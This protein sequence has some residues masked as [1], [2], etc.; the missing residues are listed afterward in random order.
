M[1]ILS[2]NSPFF[3]FRNYA[4]GLKY[5]E[6]TRINYDIDHIEKS[7]EDEALRLESKANA[8][9]I[10]EAWK[11][12]TGLKKPKLV[13]LNVSGGGSRSALWV[14]N[15]L[16]NL[17]KRTDFAVSK[18]LQMITGASGGMIGASY[19]REIMHQY[20]K[21][22]IDSPFAKAFREN[23]AADVLNRLAFAACT[24]DI[25]FRYQSVE[26]NGE[27]YTKDRG[28]AFESQLNKNT[29]NI[30]DVPLSYYE[31]LERNADV[32]LMIFT[33]TIVNDGRR[34]LMSSQP[35]SFM[36]NQFHPNSSMGKSYENIDYINFF[37]DIKPL[38]IQFS[39]VM[40]MS[41]T[42]PF[43]MPM[44]TLP[45]SPEIQLMDAGL[46]DNYGGKITMDYLHSMQDWIKENTSGVILLQ[47]RD[48]KKYLITKQLSRFH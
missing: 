38:E 22:E 8:I 19:Y 42:F 30:L 31:S 36:N 29:E 34:L 3:T 23:M 37:K 24:N 2:V 40:R 28:F 26:V 43:V 46:R 13:V 35:M 14:L 47:I 27:T 44:V 15:C 48:T 21:K 33:P 1:D 45:T 10:L 9:A 39:S 16:Q 6:E 32:P 4:Y 7:R 17:D 12:K 5:S 41:A 20:R 11:A 25:F 18:H